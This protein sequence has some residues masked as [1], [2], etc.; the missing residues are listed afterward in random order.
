M[1]PALR[2]I[3]LNFQETLLPD[4]IPRTVEIPFVSGKAGVCIGVRRCGKST[5]MF[6]LMQKYLSQGVSK[7]NIL[8]VNFFDDRLHSLHHEGLGEILEAY[9][10][11][12]PEKKNT[13][14][15]Y[16]FFDEIQVAPGWEPFIDRLMRT[17]KCEVYLTGSSAQMLGKEIATQM[18]GRAISWEL[19]PFS[20]REFLDSKEIDAKGPWSTKRRLTI[21]RAF[22]PTFRTS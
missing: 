12:Y 16:C 8:Y 3:I 2:E 11:L 19:F 10:S 4:S 14:T 22:D 15:V 13:E 21:Q 9:F 17:E 6:Q 20:F 5:L 7:Q 18:R 1:V